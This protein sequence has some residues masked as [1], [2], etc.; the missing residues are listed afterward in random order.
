MSR[1]LCALV[2]LALLAPT[3][4]TAA[5]LAEILAPLPAEADLVVVLD[6]AAWGRVYREVAA[7]TE[8]LPAVAENPEVKNL[9]GMQRTL[10]D[11]ALGSLKTQYGLDLLQDL[12]WA[13]AGM[14]MADGRAPR[15]A[16]VALGRM[17]ADLARKIVPEGQAE[18]LAGREVWRA[19]SSAIAVD[20]GKRLIAAECPEGLSRALA[21]TEIPPELARRF[22]ELTA[23]PGA[24]HYI[25]LALAVPEAARAEL[26][27]DPSVP[28]ATLAGG[29]GWVQLDVSKDGVR[30]ALGCDGPA[31]AQKAR[32]LLQGL[33]ESFV[34]GTYLWRTYA[35][36][37]LALDL[38]ELEG[39]PPQLEGLLA[40]RPAL[41]RTIEAL[42]PRPEGR[43]EVSLD[44]TTARLVVPARLTRGGFL[45]SGVLAAVA[46][47]AFIQYI[48]KAKESEG[49]ENLMTLARLEEL[50]KVE[51]GAY[52]A[53]GRAPAKAPG[54]NAQAWPGDT[55]FEALG[56][57]PLEPVYFSYEVEVGEDGFTAY[58]RCDLDGDGRERV[59]RY[60]S[61]SR[62]VE[63]L[64]PD[65]W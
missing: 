10:L 27:R 32:R 64:T 28:L 4:S 18:T 25:R 56:F 52:Q 19:P 60:D 40:N 5:D 8:A 65:A 38:G 12:G 43:P 35:Y 49:R 58:A 45:L 7:E 17:P 62:F 42:L 6:L 2:G 54:G 22:P 3:P 9:L 31:A 23:R 57:K 34:A 46:V 33:G 63:V 29:L 24:D 11:S 36:A 51:R 16:I 48:H 14:V 30:I 39:V 55:C 41:V 53:C 37:A 59:L 1:L 26:L 20:P 61:K 13:A 47:P 21:A 44:G 50:R 15:G